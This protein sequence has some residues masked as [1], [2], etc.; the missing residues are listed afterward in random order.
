VT[1]IVLSQYRSELVLLESP[2][3]SSPKPTA[4]GHDLDDDIPF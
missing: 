4:A 3:S 2:L 1:E